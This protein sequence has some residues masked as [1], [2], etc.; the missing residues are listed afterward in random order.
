MGSMRL[1]KAYRAYGH[2]FTE[3]MSGLEAGMERFVAL[4]RDF[5]GAEN[6]RQRE[7]DKANRKLNLALLAFDDEVACECYG[8]EAVYIGDELVGIVTSGGYGHRV[9]YSLAFAYLYR[10]EWVV[11]GQA[12]TVL[13]SMGVRKAHVELDGVYDVKNERLRS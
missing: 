4:E 12:V 2:E 6:L 10:P 9:G 8:N 3:E 5:I 11:Q 7:A 13:T 1:E